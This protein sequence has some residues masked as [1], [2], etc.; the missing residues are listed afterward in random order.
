MLPAMELAYSLARGVL[1][2]GLAFGFVWTIEGLDRVPAEGPAIL[3]SNHTSY[4][5]PL[6]LAWVADARH[7]KVRFLAKAELFGA[8][9]LGSLLRATRQIPVKRGSVSAVHALDAAVESLRGGELVTVF[10]EG[11][12]SM[13]LDPMP[14]K[15]GTA[16]LAQATNVPVTP[17]G[18]WGAHR[19]MFKGRRPN[20]E[21][22]VAE[23]AVIG[24][25]IHIAPDEPVRDA[26]DRIMD[27]I[28][29]CVRRARAIY[30]QR[31]RP[32]DEWWWR[33]PDS[34]VLRSCHKPDEH[35]Q[36]HE[37]TAGEATSP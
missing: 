13:D 14:G 31:P 18:L 21:P 32:G 35:E 30:P 10:P 8:P 27:A 15:S 12:I 17:I 37:P 22:L 36:E 19:V 23:V 29:A 26:T 16:R 11:T 3:A 24:E 2:P 28:C 34:A 1:A 25:P 33:D 9:G 4:L 6:A 7:R 5:D 20:I